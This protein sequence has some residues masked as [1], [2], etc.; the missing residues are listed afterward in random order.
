MA[1]LS[2]TVSE[3]TSGRGNETEEGGSLPLHQRLLG[4]NG[5]PHWTW[6]FLQKPCGFRQFVPRD[7]PCVPSGKEE[8]M[9]REMRFNLCLHMIDQ[10]GERDLE[11]AI[12]ALKRLVKNKRA[13]GKKR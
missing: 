12:R 3:N 8:E 13:R 2:F 5:V 10:M 7:V 6:I 11:I 4:D 1:I 9:T